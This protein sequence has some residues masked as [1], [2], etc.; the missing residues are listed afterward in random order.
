MAEPM[1]GLHVSI[2]ESLELAFDRAIEVGCTTFQIFTR[3][4]RGW[5]FK[6]LTDEQVTAFRDRRKSSGFKKVVAHMPYLPNLATP[7]RAMMK[8]SRHSFVEEVKRCDA[9]GIDFLVT[10]LGSHAGKGSLVGVR[11]VA[12]ACDEALVS[13]D[14]DTAILLENMA[15]QKNSV[16]A[17]LE[18]LARILELVKRPDRVAVCLD[19]CHIFA[20][21]FDLTGTGAVE[22]TMGIFDE[23]VGYEMLKVVHLNDSKGPLGAGL[24]RHENIGKGKIGLRGMKAFLHHR[25]ILERPI[26]LETPY[27]DLRGMKESI[28]TVKRLIR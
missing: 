7:D 1:I 9:L 6:P 13:S 23:A 11:N 26:I 14:G 17:R 16:G 10:H 18:E 8:V 2:A 27:K 28:A 22:S 15:G 20:S 19:T 21:G 24:D 4:P 3:N 5:K 12:G 25:G